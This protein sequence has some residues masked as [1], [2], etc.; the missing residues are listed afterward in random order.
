MGNVGGALQMRSEWS[1]KIRA[2]VLEKTDVGAY[3]G[4]GAGSGEPTTS[5]TISEESRPFTSS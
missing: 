2:V 4:A 5:E 3:G 1:G